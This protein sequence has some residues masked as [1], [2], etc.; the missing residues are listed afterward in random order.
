MYQRPSPCYRPPRGL[1]AAALPQRGRLRQHGASLL[2]VIAYLGIAAM[3]VLGAVSLLTGAFGSARANQAAEEMVGI[4]TAVRKLYLGQSYPT[5][6]LDSTL[7]T[8]NAFPGTLAR[9]TT[10]NTVSNSWGGSVAVTGAG[11]TFTIAYSAVPRDVCVNMLSG[12]S[13]WTQVKQGSGTPATVFPVTA[14]AAADVCSVT[15]AAGNNLV[16]TAN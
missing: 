14:A 5:G 7:L 3:V 9:D 1:S 13:G 11:G 12:A 6:S 2:E 16:F 10:A 15:G 4:R 8:V